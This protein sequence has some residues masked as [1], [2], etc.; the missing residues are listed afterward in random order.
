MSS[1]ILRSL[2]NS[3]TSGY[4]GRFAQKKRYIG[5]NKKRVSGYWHG[6]SLG[7]KKQQNSL[8]SF[9]F[10]LSSNLCYRLS[11]SLSIIAS[12]THLCMPVD[13]SVCYYQSTRLYCSIPGRLRSSDQAVLLPARQKTQVPCQASSFSWKSQECGI[14][15]IF[16][17]IIFICV[18]PLLQKFLFNCSLR[19]LFIQEKNS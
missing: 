2:Q 4:I 10:Q 17:D 13:R 19:F 12:E 8:A 15:F 11:S 5:S 1:M 14:S 9:C 18:T 3:W 6:M 16:Q 7:Q